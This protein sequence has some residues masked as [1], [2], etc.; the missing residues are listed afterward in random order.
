MLNNEH[1]FILN[2]QMSGINHYHLGYLRDQAGSYLRVNA[3]WISHNRHSD[4]GPN[5]NLE[6]EFA[7][8]YIDPAIHFG[9]EYYI[10]MLCKGSADD[11][12]IPDN[13]FV[14]MG[15][16]R[17]HRIQES[18][19]NLPLVLI[20][21]MPAIAGDDPSLV[22]AATKEMFGDAVGTL[23]TR[24]DPQQLI[25]RRQGGA[26]HLG[27]GGPLAVLTVEEAEALIPEG[28]SHKCITIR[29]LTRSTTEHPKPVPSIEEQSRSR[30]LRGSC[31]F[32]IKQCI[33]TAWGDSRTYYSL[34]IV[35]PRGTYFTNDQAFAYLNDLQVM[36]RSGTLPSLVLPLSNIVS[37]STEVLQFGIGLGNVK[38]GT[39]R[40][41][42]NNAA[43]LGIMAEAHRVKSAPFSRVYSASLTKI[44]GLKADVDGLSE[45]IRINESNLS[46]HAAAIETAQN[47]IARLR[48]YIERQN[49]SIAT[50][51]TEQVAIAK[52]LATKSDTYAK[53]QVQFETIEE[54]FFQ[55]LKEYQSMSGGGVTLEQYLDNMNVKI[56]TLWVQDKGGREIDVAS[57][58]DIKKVL[59][60]DYSIRK[61]VFE[62]TKPTVFTAVKSDR[63]PVSRHIAGPW[64]ILLENR[65][66]LFCRVRALD[67]RSIMG[68]SYYDGT[69]LYKCHPHTDGQSIDYTTGPGDTIRY[70]KQWQDP[71]LGEA[72]VSI[73]SAMNTCNVK[74]A[75]FA[76]MTWLRGA[77]VAD[78]WGRS[79]VLFPREEDYGNELKGQ[80]LLDALGA[81]SYVNKTN[82]VEL[83]AGYGTVSLT[84][85][86][87]LLIE[88][89]R[90]ESDREPITRIP[91]VY[92]SE[93]A[94]QQALKNRQRDLKS[95]YA[96]EYIEEEP[97]DEDYDEDYDEQ[98]EY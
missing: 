85:D 91:R 90:R 59:N 60:D 72:S 28:S 44:N 53:L 56:V 12:V 10:P 98:E 68:V 64:Q 1:I 52:E 51:R 80:E 39:S 77:Y 83:D 81:I 4:K 96:G 69:A 31:I 62:T 32:A 48:A 78:S 24:V 22:A 29:G 38:A 71:C 19:K 46:N 54:R 76:M 23:N 43:N 70:I 14:A 73:N 63:T 33:E 36:A 82:T 8:Q 57:V 7:R 9:K 13:V 75:I 61:L 66:G 92:V 35:D 21:S 2:D 45:T 49:K 65:N 42:Q 47:E 74:A 30:I 55:K 3:G 6:G 26:T 84:Q 93:E 16:D 27:Y 87:P 79:F 88:A 58:S 40:V 86:G 18:R 17:Q 41:E 11:I 50:I 67:Q 15:C 25:N 97:D 5:R 89:Y 37:A 95:W 20:A 34:A 94:A